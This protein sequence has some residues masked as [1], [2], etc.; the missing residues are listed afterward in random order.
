[1]SHLPVAQ[2]SLNETEISAM[3][4]KT[5]ASGVSEAMWMNIEFLETRSTSDAIEH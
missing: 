2:I 5:V 4:C 3:L 1:M